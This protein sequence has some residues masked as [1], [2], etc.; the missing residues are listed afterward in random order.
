M[1]SESKMERVFLG[2][3]EMPL[4]AATNWLTEHIGPDL[5]KV[6]LALPG[7]R[8]GRLLE[9][10]LA[11]VHGK[12]LRAPRIVTA[13]ALSDELLELSGA[14]AGRL[15][16]TL[17]WAEG[18][19][20]L[21]PIPIGR[22][23][24]NPPEQ[25]DFGGWWRLAEEVRTL[26][27]EVAAEGL[28]FQAVA[29]DETLLDD[30]VTR[31]GERQRWKALA[32]AQA[33][34]KLALDKCE[35]N[36]PH[37]G[38]KQALEENKLAAIERVVMIGVVEANGLLRRALDLTPARCSALIFAPQELE[39]TF[40]ELGCLIPA[41]W[42]GRDGSLPLD[43]WHVADRPVEQAVLARDTIAGWNGR[44]SAE[45]ITIGLG[46]TDVGPF[47][48]RRLDEENIYGRDAAGQ[49]LTSSTPARLLAQLAKFLESRRFLD[50]ADLVRQVDFER[51]LLRELGEE[52]DIDPVATLDAY[53]NGHYP[54]EVDGSWS[55]DSSDA[56][57]KALRS[58][59]E[60][61]WRCCEE[62]LAGLWDGSP[63]KLGKAV[64]PLRGFLE[65]IYAGHEF[66]LSKEASREGFAALKAIGSAL[67]E[68]ET[69]PNE[70]TPKCEAS[71]A[72]KLLNR[73]LQAGYLPPAPADGDKPMIEML[74]W[75]ELPL[76]NAP[77]LVVVGFEDGHVPESV[78]GDA[79]LP[80]QLRRSLGIL[81]DEKRMARDL[82]ASELLVHSRE[83]VA[84]ITGRRSVDGD[85]FLPS[86]IV[87]H[88]P[89]EEVVPRVRRFL[90]GTRSATESVSSE[91]T[92]FVLPGNADGF[93]LESISVTDFRTYLNSPYEYFLR[94][95]VKVESLDDRGRELDARSFGNLAHEVLERFGRDKR[96]RDKVEAEPIAKFLRGALHDLSVELFGARPLPA[97]QLQV[98]QLE[99]RLVAF[100]EKQAARRHS[101]WQ[102]QE[103]EWAPEGGSIP[104]DVDGEPVKLRG[105]IDRIDYHGTTKEWAIWDY[106]TGNSVKNPGTAHLS[107]DGV[108][109]DLQLPLYC[110]LVEELLD[111][112]QPQQLGYVAICQEVQNV[113]FLSFAGAKGK[114]GKFDNLEDSLTSA[115]EVAKDVVRSIRKGDF[116]HRESF[117]PNE[118]EPILRAIGG[119]GL[120]EEGEEETE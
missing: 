66:D 46:N 73:T 64:A 38:R 117:D 104:F 32:A 27:G 3:D 61:V 57:D 39:Q 80:N 29:D 90:Q 77:A 56:R 55:A 8:S 31:E 118:E 40:D 101:G 7:A 12:Q 68:I 81:D 34:M 60:A 48:S 92:N 37:L 45:E 76:D 50:F 75:L 26:F 105:R 52:N 9:D 95:V 47:V 110:W 83:E 42:V 108:W 23:L 18:L 109:R 71:V 89:Q 24:A 16:R 102:I 69:L 84:F 106:K 41:E 44:F 82:Y 25:D 19:K 85:P 59:M 10:A 91:A 28:D 2:W 11:R 17:A 30:G 120:V 53:F 112:K 54:E 99:R 78:R 14:T 62:L 15:A 33:A 103:V 74:G 36:D 98:D 6:V 21:G 119:L 113:G 67:S 88:C 116:F 115:H 13:G 4:A 70:M 114:V 94:R 65:T 51:A 86:R 111:E 100:A 58:S 43:K 87:F 22:I 97:I 63:K 49:P 5:S 107:R 93:Q 1:G 79:Y 20:S 35:L 96:V 72:L